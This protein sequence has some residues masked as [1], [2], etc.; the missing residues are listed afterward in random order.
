MKKCILALEVFAVLL[1]ACANN[2]SPFTNPADAKIVPGKSLHSLDAKSDSVNAFSTQPCTVEV[3]LPKLLDSFDVHLTVGGKDSIIASGP[4]AGTQFTFPLTVAGPGVCSLKVVVVKSNATHDSISRAL[5]VY[6]SVITMLLPARDSL[7]LGRT[8]AC[9][10]IV[11]HPELAD[12][13]LAGL[14]VGASD[15]VVFR[16]AS[17]AA[18]GFRFPCLAAGAFSLR[19]TTLAHGIVRDSL[20]K[21]FAGYYVL[22]PQASSFHVLM[23]P[24][25]FTFTFVATDLDS[26]LWGGYTWTGATTN[27]SQQ[28]IFPPKNLNHSTLVR[29]IKVLGDSTVRKF[30]DTIVCSAVVLY[31]DSMVSGVAVCT[32]FVSDTTKPNILLISPTDSV[33]PIPSPVTVKALVTDLVGIDSVKFDSLSMV[34]TNDTALF[35]FSPADS[36]RHTDSIIAIDRAGNRSRLLLTMHIQARNVA[37]PQVKDTTLSRA[38]SAGLPFAP[39]WLDTCVITDTSIH[40]KAEYAKD[41]LSWVITDSAGNQLS[42][43]A[44]HIFTVPFPRD[45]S[46]AGVLIDSSFSGTI[47][48][49]FKVFVTSNPALYG[50]GQPS[51]FVTKANFPPVITFPS[52]Q[53]FTNFRTDTIY[54][55]TITTAHDPNDPLSSLNWSFSKGKHFKVDSQYSALRLLKASESAALS[56]INPIIPLRF[57]NRHIV[58]D[59]VTAA[60]TSFEGTDTITFTV[61]DPGGLTA[62]KK[63]AFTRPCLIFHFP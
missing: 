20:T 24:D 3:Y 29:T 16:S 27:N 43:P 41:S 32:L 62:V 34:Y 25:T 9:S 21:A 59:T 14:L 55:D 17:A 22:A 52:G 6:S 35:V 63:V 8:Y 56:V 53:C 49:A 19:V 1:C 33:N 36:G 5:T 50:V 57:F 45:S 51:F 26:N 37:P 38:T 15:T 48:L 12:S 10:L 30:P 23:P 11:S 44:S 2:Q 4:I 13:I 54:L 7:L 28:T 42:V 31:P 46:S 47:K 18:V 60:D 61:T 58:I 40:A 39:I